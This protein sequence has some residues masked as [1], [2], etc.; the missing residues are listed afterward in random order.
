MKGRGRCA[1]VRKVADTMIIVCLLAIML[2]SGIRL[3]QLYAEYR[4]NRNAYEMI[5]DECHDKED[6]HLNVDFEKLRR[7][8]Q[9]IVGWIRCRELHI[10]YPIVQAED[11]DRY[12]DRMFDGSYGACG[13]LFADAAT[14][15]PFRQFNTIVYGHHMRDGSM[16][17]SLKKLK[18][19]EYCREHPAMELATP[20]GNYELQILA[21]LNQPSDSEVFTSNVSDYDEKTE[22][23]EWIRR[24]AEYTTDAEATVYDRLAVLSTCAY[25]YKN[26]KYIVVC[27]MIQEGRR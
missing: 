19:P 25:E 27:R 5:A 21:F 8:N 12:L 20:E 7:I 18:D 2:I 26:A 9:D 10:D 13:T 17:G 3:C 4:S 14:E 23:L 22:Y 16:F 11:N 1:A 6:E 24:K 15:N